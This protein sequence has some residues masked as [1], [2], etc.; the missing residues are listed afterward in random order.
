MFLS[1]AGS[2]I[3]MIN[4]LKENRALLKRIKPFQKHKDSDLYKYGISEVEYKTISE[5]ELIA[6]RKELKKS[7]RKKNLGLA[8]VFMFCVCVGIFLIYLLLR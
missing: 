2:I 1:N 6:L 8:I 4:S 7:H 5:E 3:H